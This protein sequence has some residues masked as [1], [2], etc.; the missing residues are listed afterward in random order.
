MPPQA[1]Q[2][3]WV[4]ARQ[5]RKA[6]DEGRI[7]LADFQ[8]N[9][10]ANEVANLGTVA[11]AEHEP[12][13]EYLRWEVLAQAVRTFWLMVGPKLRDRPEAWPRVRL[14]APAEAEVEVPPLAGPGEPLPQAP[15]VEGPHRR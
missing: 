15:H 2:L 5:T 13:A 14:P 6:V 10:E 8:G 4:K 3:H 12:T 11:H 9:Q 7:T 1:C